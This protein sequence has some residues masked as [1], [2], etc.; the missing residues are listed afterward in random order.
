MRQRLKIGRRRDVTMR[1]SSNCTT[2]V[3]L[4]TN[5]RGATVFLLLCAAWRSQKRRPTGHGRVRPGVLRI[6][7]CVWERGGTTTRMRAR[8]QR[9]KHRHQRGIATTRRCD[10]ESAAGTAGVTVVGECNV[11]GR[12][13]PHP[14]CAAAPG[15]GRGS[16][17][18]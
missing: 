12:R 2:I 16:V 10:D 3:S 15:C 7:V 18:W 8:Q 4:F 9:P 14:Q 5:S 17:R 13:F 6:G 1:R 11:W